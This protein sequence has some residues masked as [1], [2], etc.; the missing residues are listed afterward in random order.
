LI[1]FVLFVSLLT[2]ACQPVT[3]SPIAV[4]EGLEQAESIS[5]SVQDNRLSFRFSAAEFSRSLFAGRSVTGLDN[6]DISTG[7][8]CNIYQL[9]AVDTAD[10]DKAIWDF[11][12]TSNKD[13]G[14][15]YQLQ[16]QVRRRHSY[17]ILVLGG[18]RAAGTTDKPV[19][20][21]AGF[22][23]AKISDDTTSITL[24]LFTM[25]ADIKFLGSV[26]GGSGL[27]MEPVKGEAL[28]LD[29]SY[30]W[31]AVFSMAGL[32]GDNFTP[33]KLAEQSALDSPV[34]VNAGTMLT[35]NDISNISYRKT[36]AE[37]VT[38]SVSMTST[39]GQS[40]QLDLG[41]RD[42]NEEGTVAFDLSY[43]PFAYG[44]TAANWTAKYKEAADFTTPLSA[45]DEI[46]V[47]RIKNDTTTDAS[48]AVNIKFLQAAYDGNL[49][50]VVSENGTTNEY[51]IP[52]AEVTVNPGNLA[53]KAFDLLA[54]GS[55]P[56]KG[57][58]AGT[59]IGGRTFRVYLPDSESMKGVS[60]SATTSLATIYLKGVEETKTLSLN[61]NN[62]LFT[63]NTNI[64]LVLEGN[65][66]LEIGTGTAPSLLKI[67][68]AS[69]KFTL[70]SG[71]ILGAS[72]AQAIQGS[73][74]WGSDVRTGYYSEDNVYWTAIPDAAGESIPASVLSSAWSYTTDKSVA[75]LVYITD[76]DFTHKFNYP[77][78]DTPADSELVMSVGVNWHYT[79]EI[80]WSSSPYGIWEALPQDASF[81][82]R[83]AYT[84]MLELTADDGYSF[85]TGSLDCSYNGDVTTSI[86]G[87][88]ITGSFARVTISFLA[89]GKNSGDGPV[90]ED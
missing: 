7:D 41:L 30:S 14:G 70:E 80:T 37:T 34:R 19:L 8:Y 55:V 88:A 60:L 39:D 85:K 64:H 40:M 45:Q 83:T 66:T 61:D 56:Y 6:Y 38:K 79:A 82:P 10:P 67:T 54:T 90:V 87:S 59:A 29:C 24:P 27:T 76:F 53:Q 47:W 22:I 11:C 26:A 62:P 36:G 4:K 78:V 33:L 32:Y 77:I 52:L 17:N 23:R 28:N 3:L 44:P 63:L 31:T 69:S 58:G 12:Q 74:E 68:G 71:T 46:P 20:L 65:I 16:I 18:Y 43:S 86:T 9:I 1:S 51:P 57:V 21:V 89:T 72:S 84:A 42:M 2:T 49:V 25:V 48:G 50:E 75:A 73:S 13:A 15:N 81:S 5:A 35:L